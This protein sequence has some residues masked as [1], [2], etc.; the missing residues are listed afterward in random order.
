MS[1]LATDL[2][3]DTLGVVYERLVGINEMSAYFPCHFPRW[4]TQQDYSSTEP[5][6]PHACNPLD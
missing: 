1:K 4:V 5:G 6:N 3:T 2:V